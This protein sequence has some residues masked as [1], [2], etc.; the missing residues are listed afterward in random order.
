MHTRVQVY[1]DARTATEEG[2]SES[3]MPARPLPGAR[4]A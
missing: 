3:K 2:S 1:V 4:S